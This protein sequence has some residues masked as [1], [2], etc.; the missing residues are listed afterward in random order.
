[1]GAGG[2][3]SLPRTPDDFLAHVDEMDTADAG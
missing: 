3:S 2:Y 1:M